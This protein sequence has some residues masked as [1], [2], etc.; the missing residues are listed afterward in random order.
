MLGRFASVGDSAELLEKVRLMSVQ[1]AVVLL[2][3]GIVVDV[4]LSRTYDDVAMMFYWGALLLAGTPIVL[5]SLRGLAD[6]HAHV[7]ELVTI[8]IV[9]ALASTFFLQVPEIY[10]AAF[11]A[12]TMQLGALVE[13]WASSAAHRNIKS[14]ESLIPRT[15]RVVVGSEVLERDVDE[16]KVDDVLL[17]RPGDRV[18]ADGV[19]IEGESALDQA[20]ITGESLPVERGVGDE[21]FAG[22]VNQSGALKVQVRHLRAD[23]TL[24]RIIRMI[25]QGEA[26]QPDILRTADKFF[27]YYAPAILILAAAVFF[28]TFD[29]FDNNARSDAARRAIAILVVGCPCPLILASPIAILCGLSRAARSG[30][31]VKAGAFLEAVAGVKTVVFDK[32]GTLT[33][34]KIRVVSVDPIG[35][36]SAEDVL[37]AAAVAEVRSN[38]PLAQAILAEAKNR[39]LTA[40]EP[41]AFEQV[42]GLGVRAEFDGKKV[43]VGSRKLMEQALGVEAF[44]AAAAAVPADDA[45]L[46]VYVAVD[47]RLAGVVRMEDTVREDAAAVIARLKEEGVERFCL[48]TGDRREVAERVAK[49][50]GI[51]EVHGDLLPQEKIRFIQEQQARGQKVAMIGDGVN[52]APALVAADVGVAVGD[53]ATDVALEAANAAILSGSLK[54]LPFFFAISRKTAST[55]YWNLG[56]A[57]GFNVIALGLAALGYLRADV[58]A[59]IHVI[60]TVVVIINSLSLNKIGDQPAAA[61]PTVSE[62]AQGSLA[63]GRG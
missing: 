41:T 60:A 47:G 29:R 22:S 14:L 16:L 8:A 38:H 6:G 44:T 61:A 39:G 4:A 28:L 54:P 27:M 18:G 49:Q 53:T 9:A 59:V 31:A 32:T 10:E 40:G 12:V 42:G 63:L 50:V 62:R 13:E 43:L 58:A 11:V 19:I 2:G 25:R 36:G 30:V 35:S 57:T 45:R 15:V 33:T 46:H 24:G 52:D 51:T 17:V 34:G 1:A 7:D 48:L 37:R 20:A 56:L 55:I 23:S 3:G 26:F 5:S 21:V